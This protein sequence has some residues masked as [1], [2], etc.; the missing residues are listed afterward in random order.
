[1]WSQ[2]SILKTR[3]TSELLSK[4][5]DQFKRLSIQA[6]KIQTYYKTPSN[7]GRNAS[8]KFDD[9]V[10]TQAEKK[11]MNS[12]LLGQTTLGLYPGFAHYYLYNLGSET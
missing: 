4:A 2:P 11:S 1:M 6:T 9:I 8:L 7:F 10:S 3:I 5:L 12:E